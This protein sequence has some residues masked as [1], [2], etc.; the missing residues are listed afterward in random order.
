M[1]LHAGAP[2]RN[3][4]FHIK[5]SLPHT[6]RMQHLIIL[7]VTEYDF[8]HCFFSGCVVSTEW[9]AH[10]SYFVH[11]ANIYF[12]CFIF[13]DDKTQEELLKTTQLVYSYQAGKMVSAFV[14]LFMEYWLLLK[15]FNLLPTVNSFQWSWYNVNCTCFRCHGC[16]NRGSCTGSTV[17]RWDLNRQRDGRYL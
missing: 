9:K 6:L 14:S 15:L 11:L 13:T 10:T 7:F 12:G 5:N 4:L 1:T 8:R 17:M 16:G 2:K 3:H